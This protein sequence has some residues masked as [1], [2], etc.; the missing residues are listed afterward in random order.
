[1]VSKC[2][3]LD[4]EGVERK[5]TLRSTGRVQYDTASAAS[6]ANGSSALRPSPDLRC[7]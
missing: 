7:E 3:D 2:V 1:M 5:K 4:V 6:V